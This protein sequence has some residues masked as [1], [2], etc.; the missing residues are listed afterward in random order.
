MA[1]VL[2]VVGGAISL[3]GFAGQIAQGAKFVCEM[4]RDIQRAP[5]DLQILNQELVNI[6]TVLKLVSNSFVGHDRD[7]DTALKQCN[8]IVHTLSEV[9]RNLEAKPNSSRRVKVWKQFRSALQKSDITGYTNQLERAKTQ[10]IHCCLAASQKT[11]NEGV[12]VLGDIRDKIAGLSGLPATATAED[13]RKQASGTLDLLEH[14]TLGISRIDLQQATSI[15]KLRDI[16][17]Q[18]QNLDAFNIRYGASISKIDTVTSETF[19]LMNQFSEETKFIRDMPQEIATATRRLEQ[20]A[21]IH[22]AGGNQDVMQEL[23]ESIG[24]TVVQH[25]LQANEEV[26]IT[27]GLTNIT[28]KREAASR[29]QVPGDLAISIVHDDQAHSDVSTAATVATVATVEL[30]LAVVAGADLCLQ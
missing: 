12:L 15:A 10:L 5:K 29:I 24:R 25:L 13:I 19:A 18:A 21:Y 26:P 30:T 8:E 11:N 17:E 20:A 2:G 6:T 16:L 9:R 3:A 4:F 22:R 14:V 1:E 27:K 23:G 7:L 28:E